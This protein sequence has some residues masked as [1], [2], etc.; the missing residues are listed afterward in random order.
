[1]NIY[2]KTHN[3]IYFE[4]HIYLMI[5]KNNKTQSNKIYTTIT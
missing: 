4:F 3:N 2:L 1:M 5:K